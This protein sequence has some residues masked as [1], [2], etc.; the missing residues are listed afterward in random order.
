MGRNHVHELN[1][2]HVAAPIADLLSGLRNELWKR[3]RDELGSWDP[4]PYYACIF[5][6]AARRD[7]GPDS[8]IDLLLVRPTFKGES[9]QRRYRLRHVDEALAR[10]LLAE[11]TKDLSTVWETQ[12]ERLHDLVPSWTGNPLQIVDMSV[13]EW[14]DPSSSQRGLLN[15]V[16]VDGLELLRARGLKAWPVDGSSPG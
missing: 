10:R 1:R 8:D 16:Q 12:L 14:L 11:P 5:G 7:G 4:P 9:R 3:L 6:S 15:D 13:D 2:D